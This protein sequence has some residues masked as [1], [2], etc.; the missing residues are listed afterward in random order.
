[1]RQILEMLA[2]IRT[3]QAKVDADMK[4]MQEKMDTN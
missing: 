1:M 4:S 2:D 3:N